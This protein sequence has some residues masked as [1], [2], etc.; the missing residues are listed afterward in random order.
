MPRLHRH[1]SYAIQLFQKQQKFKLIYQVLKTT[2]WRLREKNSL[3]PSSTFNEPS[4][5]SQ[6]CMW[7]SIFSLEQY[8]Q[9]RRYLRYLITC[10]K[11]C[12]RVITVGILINIDNYLTTSQTSSPVTAAN[13]TNFFNNC[14]VLLQL[15]AAIQL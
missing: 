5:Q 9:K 3:N 12:N 7:P 8:Q 13:T 10:I 11:L 2:H 6:N 14:S 4:S 1:R 15:V